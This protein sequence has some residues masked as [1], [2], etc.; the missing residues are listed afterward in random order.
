[1]Q[2]KHTRGASVVCEKIA[3][4][5]LKHSEVWAF[6]LF[7]MWI[8]FFLLVISETHGRVVR[9]NQES[10][11]DVAECLQS[12]TPAPPPSQLPCRT[13][14]FVASQLGNGNSCNQ[15]GV[16]LETHLQLNGLVSFEGCES[17]SITS[18]ALDA[19]D[20][21]QITRNG[22]RPCGFQFCRVTNLTI[23]GLA[24]F[25]C[26]HFVDRA[27]V[28]MS[29]RSATVIMHQCTNLS[30]RSISISHISGTGLVISDIKGVNT[31]ESSNFT[32]SNSC[33]LVNSAN[34]FA[35]GIH[36]QFTENNTKETNVAVRNCLIA[37]N[38]QSINIPID[39]RHSPLPD[40]A[41]LYGY[42]TG[43]GMG[44]LFLNSTLV[45]VSVESCRFAGNMA[46]SGGGLYTH[47]QGDA[48]E[49][50]VTVENTTFKKNMASAGGGLTV[51]VGKLKD[52]NTF[53]KVSVVNTEFIE[54]NAR[55][56]GGTAL[57]AIHST[58][59]TQGRKKMLYFFNCTWTNNTAH[60][61]AA[62]DV[63]V[64]QFDHFNFGFLP[65]P[66]FHQ[67]S[68]EYNK[69]K[70]G[71]KE[72]T[73]YKNSG[74][75]SVTNFEV[76]FEGRNSFTG[77]KY[78]ALLLTSATLIME[79]GTEMIFDRNEG[80]KGGALA[81]YGFSSLKAHD[82]CSLVFQNNFA[83]K[84]GGGIYFQPFDQR[85]FIAGQ[86]CF[87]QYIGNRDVSTRNYNF[88]FTNNSAILGGKS[89]FSSSFY[90]CFYAYLGSLKRNNLTSFFSKIGNFQFDDNSQDNTTVLA[91]EGNYFVLENGQS[92][93]KTIPGMPL[94]IP[95]NVID[96]LNQSSYTLIGLE[97][98]K[99]K[100]HKA[101]N[102]YYFS[103]NTTRVYGNP[104]EVFKLTFNTQ[105]TRD[106]FYDGI[107][108]TLTDCPPGYILDEEKKLCKC[109]ADEKATAYHGIPK[110]N[111]SLSQAY[112]QSEQWAGYSKGNESALYTGPCPFE[113]CAINTNPQHLQLL[114][115][116]RDDQILTRMMC[117]KFKRGI[118]CGICEEGYSAYFHSSSH[119]CGPKNGLC[120][121]SFLFFVLSEIFPI[122]ILFTI[123]IHF[124]ISFTA[125][126]IT[127]F[128]LFSQILVMTPTDFGKVLY[129]DTTPAVKWLK[130]FQTGYTL[131]YNVFDFSFFS[132]DE[133]SFCLWDGAGMMDA[134]VVKY[135]TTLFT[136][137][138]I[139]ALIRI[140]NSRWY[141]KRNG[142][143]TPKSVVHGLSAFLV[144][145][146]SQ[147]AS[148][149]FKILNRNT[150]ESNRNAVVRHIAVTHYG[151]MDYFSEKHLV[152]AVPAIFF[153]VFVVIFPPLLLLLYPLV[154]Q[155]LSLCKLSEHPVTVAVLK[156]LQV[157]RLV[158][159]FDSFQ[160]CYRDRVRFFAGLYFV[161]KMVILACRSY[162]NNSISFLIAN[163]ATI[164]IML[165]IHAIFQ[166]YRQRGHNIID[167]FLFLNL[168][169]INSMNIYTNSMDRSTDLFALPSFQQNWI[170]ALSALQVVLIYIPII[171]FIFWCVHEL[172]KKRRRRQYQRLES[173]NN[174]HEEEERENVRDEPTS[175]LSSSEVYQ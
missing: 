94:H 133:L 116:S 22:S 160:S 23:S 121:F 109:S 163:V 174:V 65:L 82:N 64:F 9:V 27:L 165:G 124:N 168:G 81:M 53:N 169:I 13:L 152:Y 7:R 33:T 93:L 132:I 138:L 34:L 46:Y 150:I 92:S 144:L 36:M 75:V 96:E 32:H 66:K 88:T 86:S 51:G 10:G 140:M 130:A 154:L 3:K 98:K 43:G 137:A 21:V 78:T 42:G 19:R 70:S 110:C 156:A 83:H 113:L 129:N 16:V 125:G 90:S 48:T 55:Y 171:G 15:L 45:N 8:L 95:L 24:L 102:F 155:M 14:T 69:V 79:D 38:Q 108:V 47:F 25:D 139:C 112:I 61:S 11:R 166:P 52:V 142:R 29:N 6:L 60:F 76:Q 56:G 136:L 103:H 39:P 58:V 85:E 131:I 97:I 159:L 122:V 157:H 141:M 57:F 77:N 37:D 59:Y 80:L 146:Y 107:S 35:G 147:C 145:F 149:T 175:M 173:F 87:I 17:L 128:V 170:L 162:Y 167:A 26:E 117:G 31:I 20:D 30:I 63:S 12:T 143:D 105:N 4:N 74:V 91:T 120:K 119:K 100:D 41:V 153:L 99:S 135:I 18:L 104:S 28:N 1:M 151:A 127:G 49:N 148:V 68:F 114:P 72:L 84:F 101:A 126:G 111:S 134:L 158:P 67:C 123:V 73:K 118:L 44:I 89:I 40:L 164:L 161:Y 2:I 54:N 5:C 62:V 50:Y 71:S 115:D 172:I 106:A